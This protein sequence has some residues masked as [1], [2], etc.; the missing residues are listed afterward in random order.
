MPR[1][2]WVFD[3]LTPHGEA[4]WPADWTPED[5]RAFVVNCGLAQYAD[6]VAASTQGGKRLLRLTCA[7]LG[8]IGVVDFTHQRLLV[9]RVRSVRSSRPRPQ[10]RGMGRV[11]L[12]ARAPRA[13]PQLRLAFD[14]LGRVHEARAAWHAA[15]AAAPGLDDAE[16]ES[17][18]D[19]DTA[20]DEPLPAEARPSGPRQPYFPVFGL[21]RHIFGRTAPPKA[22]AA[23][24]PLLRKAPRRL[25]PITGMPRKY[26]EKPTFAVASPTPPSPA[27]AN[28]RRAESLAAL[29]HLGV[30]PPHPA[31]AAVHAAVHGAPWPRARLARPKRDTSE[32]ALRVAITEVA[33]RS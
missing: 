30:P 8:Q 14:C 25:A 1:R 23:P 4:S 28:A 3:G 12:T 6:A 18:S 22:A 7:E 21:P 19:G 33:P 11:H 13:A 29:A 10:R 15:H 26:T 24:P 31:I 20:A 16:G 2:R 5:V 32:A 17:D 27:K 9:D